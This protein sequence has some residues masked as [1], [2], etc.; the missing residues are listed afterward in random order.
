[1]SLEHRSWSLFNSQMVLSR[2]RK[3]CLLRNGAVLIGPRH[4]GSRTRYGMSEE[5]LFLIL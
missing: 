3:T 2:N 4:M 1:M 5:D